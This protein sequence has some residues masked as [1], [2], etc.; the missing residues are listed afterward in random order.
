MAGEKKPLTRGTMITA[1][2]LEDLLRRCEARSQIKR[3]DESYLNH[4]FPCRCGRVF[5]YVTD[6]YICSASHEEEA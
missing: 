5:Q 4:R 1:R 2:Q 3:G 6:L